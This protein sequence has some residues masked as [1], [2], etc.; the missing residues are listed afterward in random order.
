[1]MATK[2]KYELTCL[3]EGDQN[4]FTVLIHNTAFVDKLRDLICENQEKIDI[5]CD[6]DPTSLVLS[7][8]C[9]GFFKCDLIGVAEP[10]I[11][12]RLK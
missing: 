5:F 2:A 7:K 8:V 3:L 4:T 11:S 12:H 6:V 1:M 10:L 9:Q